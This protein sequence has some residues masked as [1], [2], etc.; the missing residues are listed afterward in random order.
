MDFLL[1][2]KLDAKNERGFLELTKNAS[3]LGNNGTSF[4]S[5]VFPKPGTPIVLN[6]LKQLPCV[7]SSNGV[8]KKN[9]KFAIPLKQA[10]VFS[11]YFDRR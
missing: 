8:K 5:Y 7:V 6:I 1:R 10:K 9:F 4:P 11:W 3:V 2:H